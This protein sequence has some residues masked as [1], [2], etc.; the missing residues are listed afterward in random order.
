MKTGQF[1]NEKRPFFRSVFSQTGGFVIGA[2]FEKNDISL[3]L[4]NFKI[5][6]SQ[7]PAQIL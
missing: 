5:T 4:Y 7:L 2:M 1:F 3:F 6:H